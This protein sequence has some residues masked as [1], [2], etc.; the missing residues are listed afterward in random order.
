MLK[1]LTIEQAK[2]TPGAFMYVFAS[3]QFLNA[4]QAKYAR[5]IRGKKANEN[6]LLELSAQAYGTTKQAYTDAIRQAFIDTYEMTPAQALVK[7]AQGG[8]V[9][10]K[11]WA[12][13]VYGIGAKA[14]VT[15]FYGSST[16]TV[17]PTTGNLLSGGKDVTD[18]SKNVYGVVGKDTIAT[19]KFYTDADGN[20]YQA[21]YDKKTGKYY[22]FCTSHKDGQK[23]DAATGKTL[24]SADGGDIWGNIMLMLEQF[25]EWLM[26]LFGS[27]KRTLTEEN[28]IPS[29]KADGFV[30][31]ENTLEA[32]SLLLILAAGGL[33]VGTGIIGGKKGKKKKLPKARR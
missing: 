2:Q 13:G 4:I 17:D 15:T 11:N 7:L 33:L 22:A 1:E 26:S 16:V 29:Q 9:A 23:I 19:Q 14:K 12:K 20:T 27:G 8:E 10:G 30:H 21:Q 31:G 24:T 18:S 28:T 6:K 25:M 3:E 32:S 5:V